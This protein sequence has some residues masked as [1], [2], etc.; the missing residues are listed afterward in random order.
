[1]TYDQINQIANTKKIPIDFDG[2]F[3]RFHEKITNSL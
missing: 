2:Y 3:G 1:M